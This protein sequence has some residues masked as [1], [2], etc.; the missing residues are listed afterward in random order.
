MGSLDPKNRSIL[1]RQELLLESAAILP[2]Q[3]GEWF[4]KRGI[5]EESLKLWRTEIRE[6]L[7]LRHSDAK[8]QPAEERTG[9]KQSN[10]K[11]GGQYAEA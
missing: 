2:Y 7:K 4:R 9:R 5:H 10:T 8:K 3:L 11:P 6:T 1:E